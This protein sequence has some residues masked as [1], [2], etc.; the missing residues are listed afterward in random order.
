MVVFLEYW[1]FIE[2]HKCKICYLIVFA[3]FRFNY[4]IENNATSTDMFFKAWLWS[5]AS[6]ITSLDIVSNTGQ[7][8]QANSTF[9]LYGVL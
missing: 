9:T 8:W 2:C 3:F 1:I 7:N 5:S 6:A 4:V